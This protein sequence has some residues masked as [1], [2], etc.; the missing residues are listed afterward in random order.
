MTRA[1]ITSVDTVSISLEAFA[2]FGTKIFRLSPKSR[3][4]AL[5]AME[6]PLKNK[7]FTEKRG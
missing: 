3:N 1:P 7:P 5:T 4:F 2:A 6:N